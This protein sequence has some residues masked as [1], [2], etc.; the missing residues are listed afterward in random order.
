MI[1]N[2]ISIDEDLADG[3]VARIYYNDTVKGIGIMSV[4]LPELRT[5][6]Y[7]RH[8]GISPSVCEAFSEAADVCLS[9]YHLPPRTEYVIEFRN[10]MSRRGLYWRKPDTTAERAWLNRDDATRD[11]AYIIALAAA[12]K[13]LGLVA[14]SRAETR[15][16]ADYY[17]GQPNAIDLE[18]AIR[19]EVSGVDHGDRPAIRRRLR[20]K[21]EQVR[22][23]D[24]YLPA[25]ASVVGFRE[26]IIIMSFVGGL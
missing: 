10:N 3:I 2:R 18:D 8:P 9:R 24:S 12:E 23:G 6:R 5:I 4:D 14:L 16:G 11:A 20:Q 17:I 22:R 7:P 19:L 1:R 25:Y 15:T 26:T 13:E 21:E